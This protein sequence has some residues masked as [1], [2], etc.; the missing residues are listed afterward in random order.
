MSF[1]F[2]CDENNLINYVKDLSAIDTRHYLKEG[3]KKAEEYISNELMKLEYKIEKDSF[4]HE[5]KSYNNIIIELDNKKDKNYLI[6]AHYDSISKECRA[7]GADDNASGVAVILELARIL[8]NIE[9]NVNVEFVFFNLEEAG[10]IGSKH[11][12]KKY[13]EMGRNLEG[14]INLDTLGTW[15]GE[16]GEKYTLTYVTDENSKD[17]MDVIL[18]NTSIPLVK[19]KDM[20][21]DDHGSFWNAQY[22]AIELTEQGVTPYMHTKDDT[23]EKLNYK[24]LSKIVDGLVELFKNLSAQ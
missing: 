22:K 6:C 3:N 19:C 11:L 23:Y 4:V 16:E 13:R 20:W 10:A 15:N 12:A 21:T 1:K 18:K 17:F 24:N 9:L 7:P 2:L 8:K 14:V 5:E